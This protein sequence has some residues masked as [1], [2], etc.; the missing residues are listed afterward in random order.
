VLEPY[1]IQQGFLMRTSRGRVATRKAYLH[2]GIRLSARLMD[3][4]SEPTMPLF[5]GQSD[6]PADSN[7]NSDSDCEDVSSD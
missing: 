2:F 3:K 4:V 5:D 1:L 7:S 6:D